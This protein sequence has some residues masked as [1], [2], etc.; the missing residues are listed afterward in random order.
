MGKYFDKNRVFQK[1]L[2]LYNSGKIFI[3]FMEDS[4]L[5]PLVFPLKKIKQS[6]IQK[7]FS[8]IAKES[9]HLKKS[10]LEL[11]FRSFEFKN[12][13]RQTLP[14]TVTFANR[15]RLLS[16]LDKQ[17]EFNAF[18]NVYEAV[19][20]RYPGLGVLLLK[21]PNLI[22]QNLGLWNELMAICDFFVTHPRPNIYIREL[23][24]EG[25]DTKFVEK[26]KRVIDMLL[27]HILPDMNES[28]IS[29]KEY[30][31]EKKYHLKY[32]LPMIRFRIL[33]KE[34]A[35]SGLTDLSIT[36]EAF[37]NLSLDCENVF[38]VENK[39]TTLS[40][41]PVKKSIVI[42]GSGYG[43]Q[44]LKDVAWLHSKHLYYWG[45]IDSDGFAILSQIRSCFPKVISLFMHEEAVRNFKHLSVKEQEKTTFKT[46]EYLTPNE[47][48]LFAKLQNSHFRLE[49]ERI[50]FTYILKKLKEIESC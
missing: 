29:F 23:G 40:F 12:I 22:I 16:L 24:I 43:V 26:N 15:A 17:A 25:I 8:L 2:K 13:G 45:D 50:N 28:S 44:V 41:P 10:N 5:F 48:K 11:S 46:L 18:A 38:I 32:P 27:S 7:E 1:A 37:Q 3:D 34:L 31:F 47:Q 6:D 21:K 9:E 49:Q 20:S 4:A 39:I 36:V 30:G 42:F 35:L 19:I 33:D 14:V